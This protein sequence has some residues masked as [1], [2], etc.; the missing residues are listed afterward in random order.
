MLR[1][2]E[3]AKERALK[4][5][6]Q[7]RYLLTCVDLSHPQHNETNS[8]G[9]ALEPKTETPRKASIQTQPAGVGDDESVNTILYVH[10]TT[11]Q[12]IYVSEF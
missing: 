4:L 9:L 8:K 5:E 7:A 3:L 2:V 1:E 10:T 12:C 6:E 11:T